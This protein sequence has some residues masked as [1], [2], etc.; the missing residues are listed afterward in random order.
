MT[1]HTKG[2]IVVNSKEEVVHYFEIAGYED[3]R[4][5][6]YPTFLSKAEE[7]DFKKG[8]N[9][10]LFAPNI[11]F[12]DLDAKRFKSDK[13]LQRALKQILKNIGYLLDD[14]NTDLTLNLLIYVPFQSN[15]IYLTYHY[16]PI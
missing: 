16:T 5:N 2:Q 8:I 11:L 1:K 14:D 12:I 10:N 15:D 6:A 13:E 3:C 9:L 4:I 7:Q